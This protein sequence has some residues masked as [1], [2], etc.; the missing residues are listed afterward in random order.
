MIAS[1]DG[2]PASLK[3]IKQLY[4]NGHAT[5][6]DYTKALQAYQ[7]YLGEIKSKQRDEAA[8]AQERYRYY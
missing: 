6:D 5:K 3:V 2:F 7:K 1:R 4:T 8:A